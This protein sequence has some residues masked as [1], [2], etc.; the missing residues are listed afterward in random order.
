MTPLFPCPGRDVTSLRFVWIRHGPIPEK[1]RP[2]FQAS[3]VTFAEVFSVEAV[4]AKWE[5]RVFLE[6]TEDNTTRTSLKVRYVG[7]LE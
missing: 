1:L 7:G 5:R 3:W 4:E 2:L 6:K